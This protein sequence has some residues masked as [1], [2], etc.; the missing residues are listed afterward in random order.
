MTLVRVR[1]TRDFPRALEPAEAAVRAD[2]VA[3]VR[4]GDDAVELL[5]GRADD[6]RP[7]GP[8]DLADLVRA[9]PSADG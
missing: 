1:T 7:L 4:A 2:G 8:G 3:V 5:E 9:Q 6:D